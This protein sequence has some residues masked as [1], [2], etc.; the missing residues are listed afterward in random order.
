M[1]LWEDF[2]NLINFYH[3]VRIFY[4]FVI[5]CDKKLSFLSFFYVSEKIELFIILCITRVYENIF[6]YYYQKNYDFFSE[7]CINL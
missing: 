5:K 3:F 7:K 2:T 4:H 6:F 1:E